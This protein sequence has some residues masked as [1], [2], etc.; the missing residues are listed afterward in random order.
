M[1][2]LSIDPICLHCLHLKAVLQTELLLLMLGVARG[3][4]ATGG[5]PVRNTHLLSSAIG[6]PLI[7][8]VILKV[9]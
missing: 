5:T 9:E 7:T 4:E 2:G 3:S 8:S 1:E 6:V